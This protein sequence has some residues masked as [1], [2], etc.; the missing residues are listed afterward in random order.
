MGSSRWNQPLI[1]IRA[2]CLPHTPWSTALL[3][4]LHERVHRA[5]RNS[6]H[7]MAR[8]LSCWLEKERCREYTF[9]EVQKY[10]VTNTYASH[11]LLDCRFRGWGVTL[12]F[13]QIGGHRIMRSPIV[14]R[15]LAVSPL[16]LWVWSQVQE[17]LSSYNIALGPAGTELERKLP[18]NNFNENLVL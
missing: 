1:S 13:L 15:L 9:R 16:H 7:S 12:Y 18:A 11:G 14:T 8:Y 6:H 4:T 5:V 2:G 17:K 3:R 10:N